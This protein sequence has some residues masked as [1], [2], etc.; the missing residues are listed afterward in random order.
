MGVGSINNVADAKEQIDAYDTGINYADFYL[1]KVFEWNFQK[2]Y[3]DFINKGG[4]I[5][6]LSPPD[7]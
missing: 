6:N 7:T 4:A 1:N 5:M 3:I 2:W